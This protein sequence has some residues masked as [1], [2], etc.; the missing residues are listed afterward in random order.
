MYGD[1]EQQESEAVINVIN[2]FFSSFGSP[3]S[4]LIPKTEKPLFC[5]SW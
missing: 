1:V 2:I 4:E 5:E 3:L